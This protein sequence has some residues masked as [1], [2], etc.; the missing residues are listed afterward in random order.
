[1]ARRFFDP[2]KG[3]WYALGILGDLLMLSLLW[4]ACCIPVLTAGASTAALYDAAVHAL[5]RKDEALLSRFFLVFKRE[6]KSGALAT[7]FWLL[8][9]AA[10]FL[11]YR[12]LLA[13]LPEGESRLVVLIFYLVLVSFFTLCVL[14]WVFPTLSRFSFSTLALNAAAARLAFGHILR[15]AALALLIGACAWLSFRFGLPLMVLPGLAA[16]L[17]SFL[18]E[19]IF[20]RY[21][22][23][24]EQD[25]PAA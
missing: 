25:S 12:G 24:P 19:P 14:A 11:V 4:G 3:L 9:L 18:I 10:E 1:M 8:I 23:S 17:A 15:S 7:L 6:L 20:S 21:D 13:V 2:E 5:R 22:R 16:W